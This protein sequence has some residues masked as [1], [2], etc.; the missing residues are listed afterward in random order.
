VFGYPGQPGMGGRLRAADVGSGGNP[1]HM[2]STRMAHAMHADKKDDSEMPSSPAPLAGQEPHSTPTDPCPL[3]MTAMTR[4]YRSCTV[5]KLMPDSGLSLQDSSN[6]GVRVCG[7][8]EKAEAG[9]R[10]QRRRLA[11]GCLLAGFDS[12]RHA[13]SGRARAARQRTRPAP[14][15]RRES[16]K[17]PAD[18]AGNVLCHQLGPEG[19]A[20][21]PSGRAVCAQ[22]PR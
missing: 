14:R 7:D 12:T 8:A 11:S 4:M 20:G 18:P 1:S 9:R 13:V 19:I 3:C 17:D 10:R 15:R 5:F 22:R 16:A 21:L 6:H 2:H